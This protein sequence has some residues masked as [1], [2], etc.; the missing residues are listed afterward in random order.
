MPV[1]K[2]LLDVLIDSVESYCQRTGQ[3]RP[4][5]NIETKSLPATDNILHPSP[6]EFVDLLAKIIFEKSI[7]ARVIIESFDLRT[8][9]VVRRKYP[10]LKTALLVEAFDTRAPQEQIRLLGFTPDIYSP[11]YALVNDAMIRF[12]HQSHMRIIPWTVDDK[13]AIGRL[14]AMGVDG[15]ITDYPNLF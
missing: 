15:L 12:C 2:P 10:Q 13:A 14:R 11:D 5:Y 7:E 4:W 1:H 8:L 3:A 6:E 9:Q